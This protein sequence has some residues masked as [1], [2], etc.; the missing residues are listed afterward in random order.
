MARIRLFALILALLAGS[1]AP[2]SA[3]DLPV[4]AEPRFESVATEKQLQQTVITALAQD[5]SGLLWLGV[6]NG[7]LRFDGLEFQP[8][9]RGTGP[10]AKP[11][12]QVRSLV[13]AHDGRLWVGTEADGLMALDPESGALAEYRHGKDDAV[14]LANSAIRAL[15]EDREGGIWIGTVGQGVQ[16]LDPATG[17][18]ENFRK[19]QGLP[20][21][22]IQSLLVDRQ[23]T[24]WVGTWR[25]MARRAV[26]DTR[27]QAVAPQL[28]AQLTWA[29][30]EAPDG[31]IWAGTRQGGLMLLEADGSKAVELDK[32]GA[33]VFSM[34]EA[35]AGR[36][37]VARVNGIEERDASGGLVR[38]IQR[39]PLHRASL[40]DDRVQ[41]MRHDP[42]GG[43][44][45]ASYGGGLQRHDT[46]NK[47]LFVLQRTAGQGRPG[48][49]INARSMVELD[50]G[51]IWVGT[52]TEG[53][54]V[55]DAGLRQR[56]VL[57]AVSGSI[58]DS[59]VTGLAQT[60]DGSIWLG[61]D[62]GTGLFRLD[63]SGHVLERLKPGEG[64]VRRLLASQDGGLW[65]ATQDGLYRWRENQLRRV[66]LEGGA[67]L[68]SNVNALSESPDGG[69]WV[70]SEQGLYRLE[71]GAEALRRVEAE[72]GQGLTYPGVVGML[73][74]PHGV[75]WVDTT[76]GLHK[77]LKWDGHR[78]AF[79][80]VSEK[81]GVGGNAFGAN[82]LED[83]R[84]RIWTQHAVYDPAQAQV[85]ILGAADG[86]DIGTAWFRA[87]LQLRDGRMLFGGSKGV[88]VAQP[89]GF[90]R[91]TYEPPVVATGVAIDGE[92]QPLALLREGLQ[93]RPG[94]HGFRIGFAAL[95]Y[96]DPA[97]SRYAYRLKG[98]DDDWTQAGPQSRSVAFGSLAPGHYRL[99]VRA[100]NRAGQWSRHELDLPIDVLPAWWQSASARALFVLAGL[101][102]LYGVVQ[103]RTL[104][105][106]NRRAALEAMVVERTQELE[107][108]SIALKEA[109]LSDPLTGL[110]NRR[111]F[112]LNI[113]ADV[114]M[115]QRRHEGPVKSAEDADLLFFLLDID[116]FKQVNDRHGHA[117][118]DALLR[119]MR[120]RLMTVFRESD[121]LVRWGG[122][123][124][125]AV[126]RS[127]SRL[128]AAE[129]AE[130]ARAAVAGQ[131]F[132]L[133]VGAPL[134]VS[135]SI[136]F[137]CFPLVPAAPRA[138]DWDTTL[139]LA[140][141]ALYEAKNSGRNAWVGVLS[142]PDEAAGE[143]LKAR[144][145]KPAQWLASGDLSV[146]RSPAKPQSVF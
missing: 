124:F 61:V 53:V 109:S 10:L 111:F 42:A 33:M 107:A 75:L 90:E 32:G 132:E 125:L 91:W 137:A 139:K 49:E 96:S 13:I 126:A 34:A 87:Y 141:A 108:L 138:L 58:G 77:L 59:G 78:A 94:Q 127:S 145:A 79:E 51:E 54:I 64:G 122:E 102:A 50:N 113:D 95:D 135:C 119:Q 144:S 7:L 40:G 89:E 11:V 116:D 63:R 71:P 140:D 73:L 70:G 36:I 101:A 27:F 114:A 128:H 55:L 131:P 129:L 66:M 1:A 56:R 38:L 105:L 103:L 19:E 82:L 47:S 136:G 26:G 57:P 98:L 133:E 68:R 117:A 81:M 4:Q 142:A 88:L 121:Y 104:Y 23:G 28:D 43:V 45:V 15:A 17:R 74:D 99:Q 30:L 44:W 2:A 134:H 22:R 123:E 41:V 118:G 86:V 106:R 25:G 110:R 97:S 83:A 14:G 39:N 69:L 3:V 80:R 120:E 5:R 12:G 8:F 21:D 18:F 46:R 72:A 84:G 85:Q 65:I 20:D 29:L 93:L 130:R 24:L 92:T 143:L 146:L 31:R 37:W 52:H 6:S 67:P 35:E 60:K 112:T 48:E 76:F 9:A 115:T 100:T 62:N 16:R